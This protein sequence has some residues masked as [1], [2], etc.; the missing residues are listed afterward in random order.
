MF[1][2]NYLNCDFNAENYNSY[3]V[4]DKVIG[5]SISLKKM[6]KPLELNVEWQSAGIHNRRIVVQ[7]KFKLMMW[8]RTSGINGSTWVLL[9]IMNKHSM[10]TV[11]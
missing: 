8:L 3:I 10:F 11:K 5:A 6:A 2:I 1:T 9:E 7:V 4:D